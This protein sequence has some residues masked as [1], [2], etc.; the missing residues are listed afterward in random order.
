MIDY[1]EITFD[2][3]AYNEL[4]PISKEIEE[5]IENSQVKNG[6]I[7]IITKHTTTG[8][9]VNENLECLSDDILKQLS[10]MFPEDGEYYHA[11]FLQS[12]GAMAG[13]PTG[14]L[15]AMV[16]GNHAVFPIINGEIKLGKAQEIYLG[17]FD[18]P[19]SRTVMIM[20][21]GEK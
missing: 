2:T 8:I 3:T 17:E 10:M 5:C 20:M 12:Y 14:H 4:V 7:Y 16:T 9:T 11:R 15:K 1:K 6:I 21:M 18:G 19:Q 13:N